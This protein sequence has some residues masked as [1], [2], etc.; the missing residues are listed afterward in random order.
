LLYQKTAK[1]TYAEQQ[2]QSKFIGNLLDTDENGDLTY[3]PTSHNISIDLRRREKPNKHEL[4][5]FCIRQWDGSYRYLQPD[6]TS[7]KYIRVRHRLL[8]TM[9]VT[10]PE[11][12]GTSRH[13]EVKIDTPIVL[14]SKHCIQDNVDLPQYNA[15]G[16]DLSGFGLLPF[17]GYPSMNDSAMTPPPEYDE[18]I[19]EQHSPQENAD[20]RKSPE[21]E[22]ST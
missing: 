7:S 3:E 10:K 1:A 18:V 14:L 4:P 15:L 11:D 21:P 19:T 8:I 17:P 2:T 12:D 9:R 22:T 16:M 13:F 6:A 5:Q 20:L